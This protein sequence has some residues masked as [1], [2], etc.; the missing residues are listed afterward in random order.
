MKK[1]KELKLVNFKIFILNLL[2]L[3][4]PIVLTLIGTV[5]IYS[6]IL[7]LYKTMKIGLLFG[8][9]LVVTLPN[10]YSLIVSPLIAKFDDKIDDIMSS[11][12]IL[13][14]MDNNRIIDEVNI[15]KTEDNN[16]NRDVV[17]KQTIIIDG[18]MAMLDDC[19]TSFALAFLEDIRDDNKKL[20]HYFPEISWTDELL[21]EVCDK[22]LS[23]EIAKELSNNN[24]VERKGFSR[25]RGRHARKYR[26]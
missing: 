19:P 24:I 5:S 6:L 3:L 14:D 22:L 23:L 12:E 11:I 25:S 4:V 16:Q 17:S 10:I 18:I 26:I 13:D 1:N 21:V 8:L 7:F 20:I 15:V 9:M 2:S